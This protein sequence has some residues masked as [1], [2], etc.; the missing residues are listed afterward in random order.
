MKP[1]AFHIDRGVSNMLKFV[2][3]I[4]IA[5]HHYAQFAVH[6][7]ISFP[8]WQMV[9]WQIFS[10][11][12]GYLGV[13]VFFFL[14]GF[15]LMESEQKRH[16]STA[17]FIDKR[18]KRVIFPLVVLAALWIPLYY[19]CSLAYPA[20][21]DSFLGVLKRIL[22]VGGWFVSA[23]LM[24][25][26]AF[27]LF[28]W[29]NAKYGIR[30]AIVLLIVSTIVIYIICDRCLGD[31]SALSIPA[32]SIGIIASLYKKRYYGKYLHCS[33]LTV[34]PALLF[35]AFYSVLVRNSVALAGHAIIN[36]L[37]L[38]AL[39]VVFSNFNPSIIFPA[40][41]GEI[42]FDIYLI[43]KKILTAYFALSGTL[44]PLLE[45]T[46]AV[47]VLVTFFVA[48]RKK[49]WKLIFDNKFS[50]RRENQQS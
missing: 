8:D 19:G 7:S 41:L 44:M 15:G 29:V 37:A 50:L 11:Q 23:I 31:F 20:S 1:K 16:L 2:S 14:S 13:A 43:H 10:S 47:V 9:V 24:M 35:T 26:V 3:A 36:Y 21:S 25:Y 39:I 40:L 4:V 45:W 17:E 27:M 5:L 33:L 22:N 48:F 28:C 42:S 46:A 30:K 12:G 34:M 18:L 38:C 6:Q 32:F 49:L